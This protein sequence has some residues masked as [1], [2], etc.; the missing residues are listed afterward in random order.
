M[1]DILNIENGIWV[2]VE[3]GYNVLLSDSAKFGINKQERKQLFRLL[4]VIAERLTKGES[5]EPLIKAEMIKKLT[6]Q[7]KTIFENVW[8]V[9]NLS[10][11]GRIIFVRRDPDS[12][13]V[14]A[15][16]KV[17][18]SLSQAVNRGVNR[19]RKFLREN[20]K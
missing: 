17:H 8:E 6:R 19:W 2:L 16:V 11:G 9:R 12:I 20:E 3:D 10:G 14:S 5:L 4:L 15:V 13:I 1:I 7:E 18:G